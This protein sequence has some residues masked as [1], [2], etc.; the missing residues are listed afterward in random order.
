VTARGIR[1][2][3]YRGGTR[4]TLESHYNKVGENLTL[5]KPRER[6]GNRS[7]TA[8]DKGGKRPREKGERNMS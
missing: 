4:V 8:K 7:L 5:E 6:S 2:R 1:G 3:R